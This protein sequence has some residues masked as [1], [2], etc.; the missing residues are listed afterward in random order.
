MKKKKPVDLAGRAVLV[1]GAASG[2]GRAAAAA[3]HAAGAR[4]AMIDVDAEELERAQCELSATDRT[5]AVDARVLAIAADVGQADEQRRFVER[6]LER[7]GRIDVLINNAGLSQG[8]RFQES[9]PRRLQ[10]LVAVNFYAPIHLT[11]LVLPSMLENREGHILNV[12]SSSATLAGPGYAAYAATKAGLIGFTRVLRRE[13][14]GSGVALTTLCPGSTI[15]GMTRA[16]LEFG[17][18]T[19]TQPHHD[20]EVPAAAMLDAVRFRR[21]SVVV[22]SRPR[23]QA[24]V[25]FIDRLLPHAM[26]RYWARQCADPDYFE[27]ASRAGR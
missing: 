16:M 8:G 27:C 21:E 25:S 13:L 5:A 26:D 3:F 9:D 20:P 12:I 17:R 14:A 4:V 15:S 11:R 22:S 24:F 23:T 6:T 2:I 19:A 1:T 18:G 7:Y 10:P